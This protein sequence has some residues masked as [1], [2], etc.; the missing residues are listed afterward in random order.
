MIKRPAFLFTFLLAFLVALPA[1]AGAP[2]DFVKKKSESLFEVVNQ[3]VG[4]KRTK[5]L[6]A[7]ARALVNYEELAKRA[8]GKHWDART[9]A[10]KKSFIDLLERLVELNYANRFQAKSKTIKYTVAY[11][12]E[13]VR[14][15]TGQA[16][17]KTKVTYGDEVFTLDYKLITKKGGE[18]TIYDAVF[19]DIS[20]EETYRESY[21]PI[22]EKEGWPS[23]ISRMEKKL[24]DLEK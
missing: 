21:V 23:L 10:E 17:V 7:E 24:K 16:I 5:A 20:L 13:K 4:A 6:K 9:D 14:E 1:F 8:L 18:P 12:G 22:I 2:T 11:S 15:S 3:P 19:D